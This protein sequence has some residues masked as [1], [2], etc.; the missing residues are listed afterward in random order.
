MDRESGL[1]RAREPS[2]ASK[3]VSVAG[4]ARRR[5][6]ASGPGSR[7]ARAHSYGGRL[8]APADTQAKVVAEKKL[9]R[10]T[11]SGVPRTTFYNGR[12]PVRDRRR[13]TVRCLVQ[14]R[15]LNVRER[16]WA[17]GWRSPDSVYYCPAGPRLKPRSVLPYQ[18]HRQ[19][20]CRG[21]ELCSPAYCYDQAAVVRP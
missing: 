2:G 8:R 18:A 21:I 13:A 11:V 19:P 16:A 7:I 15:P 10:L 3:G 17:N 9:S 1:P 6:A 4:K 14:S 20:Q 12:R 5:G